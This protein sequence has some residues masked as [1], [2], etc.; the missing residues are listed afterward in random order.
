MGYRS[1]NIAADMCHGTCSKNK[2]GAQQEAEQ[3]QIKKVKLASLASNCQSRF[4]T[5]L[6]FNAQI[7][8]A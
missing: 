6:H 4:R 1:S 2:S 5:Y 8:K 3:Q 7:H